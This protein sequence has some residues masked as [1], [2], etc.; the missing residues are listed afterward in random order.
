MSW[1]LYSYRVK[2]LAVFVMLGSTSAWLSQA[3]AMTIG[4]T[5]VSSHQNE[6]LAASIAVSDVDTATFSV[7]L[8][9]ALIY[10]KMGLSPTASMTA[11]FLPTSSNSGNIVIQ[12]QKPL[13]LPFADV[14][15][16]LNQHG[17][18]KLMP[19][20]LL[21]PLQDQVAL[22]QKSILATND[23]AIL[24]LP[25]QAELMATPLIVRN[26]MPPPLFDTAKDSPAQKPITPAQPKHQSRQELLAKNSKTI[27][28]NSSTLDSQ[29]KPLLVLSADLMP[30]L[31]PTPNR[32]PAA[33]TLQVSVRQKIKPQAL[34]NNGEV[35][36]KNNPV[37]NPQ[38][39]NTPIVASADSTNAKENNVKTVAA[40]KVATPQLATSLKD[41]AGLKDNSGNTS[42]PYV[43]KRADTL[44]QLSKPIADRYQLNINE[45]MARI[46]VQ[47][48]EAFVKQNPNRLKLAAK[49]DMFEG[50]LS[51]KF[52]LQTL[53]TQQNVYYQR[54]IMPVELATTVAQNELTAKNN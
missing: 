38:P 12:T 43:V 41:N 14:V 46:H 50:N 35:L 15:L 23:S 17:Q 24:E 8:A 47:N 29:A 27:E 52:D 31:L 18:Q 19:K 2:R 13:A 3:S 32:Q 39:Q 16:D 36:V 44:W 48:P 7:K 25:L 37:E 53:T 30:D 28:K 34:E 11:Q 9:E 5:V 40:K 49:L 26:E 21:V 20:T 54:A 10:Q 1:Q 51:K 42:I 45:V 22:N 4:Q 6:P 33:K